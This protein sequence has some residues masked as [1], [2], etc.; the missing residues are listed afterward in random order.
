MACHRWC[1]D[2]IFNKFLIV[3]SVDVV[4]IVSLSELALAAHINSK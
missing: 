3:S 1:L 4:M 2:L